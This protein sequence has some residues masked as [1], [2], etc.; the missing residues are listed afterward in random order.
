[1]FLSGLQSKSEARER[2]PSE[3]RWVEH[4]CDR[5]SGRP[6]GAPTLGAVCLAASPLP[7]PSICTAAVC[8]FVTQSC[9]TLRPHGLLARLLCPRN[10]LGQKT[11]EGCHSR[12]QGILQI[13]R[14][15]SWVCNPRYW[16]PCEFPWATY[17][18]YR[19]EL[20][21]RIPPTGSWLSHRRFQDG[22]LSGVSTRDHCPRKPWAAGS[23]DGSPL[24][25]RQNQRPWGRPKEDWWS[26]PKTLQP[27]KLEMQFSYCLKAWGHERLC[28]EVC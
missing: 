4:P 18:R 15:H 17:Q 1:M 21:K 9:P 6:C 28:S 24:C 22:S 5:G 27:R 19:G 23:L 16:K 25:F 3:R 7:W 11:G 20:N 8:V 12:L 2:K 13:L 26:E 10:S 14:I